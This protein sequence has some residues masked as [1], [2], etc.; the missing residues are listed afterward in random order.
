L[1]TITKWFL[2]AATGIVAAYAI[3]ARVFFPEATISDVTLTLAYDWPTIPYAVGVVG[4]HLF[5]PGFSIW[6][7]WLRVG[8]LILFSLMLL[9][10]DVQHLD[11]I[12]PLWPFAIGV[13]AGH[14]LWPQPEKA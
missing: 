3:C 12:F 4:G 9:L 2:L 6:E 10:F 5:W 1:R 14:I 8:G 11:G 7:E 13:F